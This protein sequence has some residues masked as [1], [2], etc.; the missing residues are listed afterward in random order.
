MAHDTVVDFYGDEQE[1][2]LSPALRGEVEPPELIAFSHTAML[3][4]RFRTQRLHRYPTLSERF[5]DL[6]P[7]RLWVAARRGDEFFELRRDAAVAESWS[8]PAYDL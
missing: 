1:N 5:P 3:P 4:V 7:T 6:D 2:D 8:I